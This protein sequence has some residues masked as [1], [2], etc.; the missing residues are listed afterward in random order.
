MRASSLKACVIKYLHGRGKPSYL[1]EIYVELS[2]QRGKE[3][4]EKFR[5]QIRGILNSSIKKNEGIFQRI[6]GVNGL[7]SLAGSVNEIDEYIDKLEKTEKREKDDVT[8]SREDALS[9]YKQHV[10]FA[11]LEANRMHGT[12]CIVPLEEL[13][14]V[15]QIGLYKGA[16][17]FRPNRANNDGQSPIPYLKK[18][19]RGSLLNLI[20]EQKN[21]N[22]RNLRVD[23]SDVMDVLNANS[24]DDIPVE[25]DDF[26]D[27][28]SLNQLREILISEMKEHLN[29]DEFEVMSKR[30]GLDGNG[31]MTFKD[32]GKEICKEQNEES[33]KSWSWQVERAARNK[34]LKKSKKLRE[35]FQAYYA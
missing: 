30:Y 25:E 15:S 19:I 28:I 16:C 10:N 8:V 6:K 23:S 22:N 31:G 13:Q 2:Q 27:D 33:A 29:A 26:T 34:L 9:I 35:V 7:Y 20:R 21:W 17:D 5:A 18:Y 3:N 14:S 24:F 32:I 11:Y 1:S 4:D 12:S